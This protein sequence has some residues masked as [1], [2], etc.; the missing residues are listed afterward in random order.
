M[1]IQPLSR[2]RNGY[3]IAATSA[4]ISPITTTTTFGKCI[5]LPFQAC[6]RSNLSCLLSLFLV[7]TVSNHELRREG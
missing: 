1:T 7:T 6:A 3:C 4:K 2:D 5:L